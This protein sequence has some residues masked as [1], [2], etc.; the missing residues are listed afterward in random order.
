M[1]S[2]EQIKSQ[3]KESAGMPIGE[4]LNAHSHNTTCKDY[5]NEGIEVDHKHNFSAMP[6][7]S[8]PVIQPKLSVNKSGDKYEQEAD[9]IAEKVMRMNETPV[10]VGNGRDDEKHLPNTQLTKN[11]T[12]VIQT[13]GASGAIV[14]NSLSNKIS[15]SAGS[16]NEMDRNTQSFMSDRFGADFSK[17]NIH[18]NEESEQMN[19]EINARAFTVGNDIY[20]N[21]GEY[22]PGSSNGKHLLA[23]ELSHVLQQ[24]GGSKKIQKD[25]PAPDAAALAETK[26]IADL[27]TKIKAFGIIGVENADATFTSAELDLVNKALGGLPVADKA[28]IKGA[29]I[30]R[31]ISVGSTTSAHYSNTQGYD[32]SSVTEDQKIE[33]SDK[34][35]GT[36]TA[37]ESIRLITHEVGHA[38]AVMPYRIA[39]AAR[40]TA[41]LKSLK[42]INE[43]NTASDAFNT[44][45]DENTAAVDENN[46]AVGELDEA[47][48]GS[49]ATEI[50]AARKKLA[51]KKT[52]W[53][54]AKAARAAK[55]TVYNTKKAASDAQEKV[56]ATKEAASQAK[57]ANIDD[58]K[59][60]A[61]AKLASMQS[62]YTA[63]NSTINSTDADSAD[64]RS[65]LTSV[66][67]A[68]KLFYDE[69]VTAD[70]DEATADAAKT[71]VDKAIED[72]NKKRD[73]LNTDKPQNTIVSATAALETKQDNC[74]KAAVMVAFNKSMNLATRRFYDFVIAN[75]IP[76]NLTTYAAQNWPHKPEEFYAEAYS[77]FVTKPT[78]LENFSKLLYDWFK[79]GKYK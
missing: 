70:V 17:V 40:D 47:V 12:P 72:R 25:D 58:F 43:A 79:G 21:K 1:K 16:G 29:K 33:L 2:T 27:T 53:D 67:D 34:A 24:N 28:A 39:T 49:D 20:F 44:A 31:V 63:A 4:T 15:E 61:T 45:N 56:L 10:I 74:F 7:Y 42:L 32:D 59:T 76:S 9:H 73:A 6:V 18:A 11:I 50:A 78:E 26:K 36:T 46:A 23:H 75:A 64:Y 52:A 68:I 14:S 60:D 65:S 22:Q 54:K 55:E 69:N 57:L 41:G 19:S 3:Q 35:F 71:V 30:V 51:T 5:N 77:Y 37:D 66:E 38:I 13:K 48:K 8:M 62:D